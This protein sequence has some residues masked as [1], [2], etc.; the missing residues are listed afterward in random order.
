MFAPRLPHRVED[1]G[2]PVSG[3]PP[4]R[5]IQ[6]DATPLRVAGIF[7]TPGGNPPPQRFR[8]GSRE[9]GRKPGC[10]PVLHMRAARG[11]VAAVDVN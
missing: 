4:D 5:T 6:R 3:C 2:G 9:N 8:C 1:G 10:H 11:Q 7:M